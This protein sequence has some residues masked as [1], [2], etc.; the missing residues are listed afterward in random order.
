M[1]LKPPFASF[2]SWTCAVHIVFL[3]F[4]T[5][6]YLTALAFIGSGALDGLAY[7]IPYGVVFAAAGSIAAIL[8]TGIAAARRPAIMSHPRTALW[9][10]LITMAALHLAAQPG[11]AAASRYPDSP[12]FPL[13]F[14][15]AI[16]F[17]STGNIAVFG[18]TFLI[19]FAAESASLSIRLI[20][21]L[22]VRLDA[23]QSLND[24]LQRLA[25]A[26]A[27][28][29]AVLGAAAPAYL[30]ARLHRRASRDHSTQQSATRDNCAK[31]QPQYAD[32]VGMTLES[33]KTQTFSLEYISE[34]KN[35]N[36]DAISDL[37]SSVV[38]FMS[39][40]FR[41]YTSLGFI[42]H[43][44]S[45]TFRL[46]SFFSR[47]GAVISDARIAVGAG[48]IGRI[49]AEK[50]SFMSGDLTYYNHELHY[51]SRNEMINS[52]LAVPVISDRKELL[53]VLAIDSKDKN[54]FQAQHK[55]LLK[56]FSTLA[57]ALI[58]NVRMRM[59]QARAAK[60]FKIFY[61]A[62]QQFGA[63]LD[64]VEIVS[65]L[66]EML[67][68]IMPFARLTA[69]SIDH[70]QQ[71][72]TISRIVGAAAELREGITFA[73][74]DGLYSTV[75]RK[76]EPMSL[77]DFQTI[78]D[79]RYRFAPDEPQNPSIHA[80]ILAPVLNEVGQCSAVISAESSRANQYRGELE[81]IFFTLIGNASVACQRAELYQRM[82]RL[83]TTD[84][85]THL[86]NHRYFQENLQ[87]E[88]ERCERYGRYVSM[89]L[90]DIDFF[91]KFNDAYGHPI[92]DIVLRET[93]GCI[94]QAIR[95]ND[96]PARYGGEEFAV[97]IPETNGQGAMAVA[98]RI[99]ETIESHIVQTEKGPLRVTVSIGCACM[100][101]HARDQAAL[102]EAADRA[103]YYSKESGRNR[104]TL[105]KKGM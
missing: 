1:G 48:I 30:V 31:S 11:F 61:T 21:S 99:R 37:L 35:S 70:E 55:E 80:L 47:G 89:L 38:Y 73:L 8:T 49:G 15:V 78:R 28:Y 64:T 29:A 66:F 39:R 33:S 6:A 43:P 10:A 18:L 62:S 86:C 105:Y 19:L 71:T 53:G 84:G 7:K 88:A 90:M 32:T 100:P 94:R 74:N 46:N 59:Y 72:A 20:S 9:V 79:R 54:A 26:L 93:A 83:A 58:T 56:R 69:V 65:G 42:F 50:R 36:P 44:E 63:S 12:L 81:Q 3:L 60:H 13:Y 91:K 77:G 98:E 87:R 97:I 27:G 40:N 101:D 17:A 22:P 5:A 34:L 52:V 16:F 25:K 4:E 67:Q 82:E 23:P 95:A 85:L 45:Q 2:L 68:K 57:A 103:L 102:I 41:A 104:T 76:C 96:F 92:G 51:Y 24:L 14:V 75:A